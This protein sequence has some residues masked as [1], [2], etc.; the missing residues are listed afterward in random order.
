MWL[1]LLHVTSKLIT[2]FGGA[3]LYL[4]AT[5]LRLSGLGK[6]RNKSQGRMKRKK[7]RKRQRQ[8]ETGG[9]KRKDLEYKEE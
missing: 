6:A 7:K 4:Y 5:L 2:A 3:R 8:K 9:Y 1:H